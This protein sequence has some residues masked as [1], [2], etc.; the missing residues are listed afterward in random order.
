M[1]HLMEM[2]LIS[3]RSKSY[4]LSTKHKSLQVA[5]DCPRPEIFQPTL[6]KSPSR[7][8]RKAL[9][10]LDFR[11]ASI[12][13]WAG[14]ASLSSLSSLPSSHTLTPIPII[15]WSR[16]PSPFIILLLCVCVCSL[17]AVCRTVNRDREQRVTRQI[18]LTLTQRTFSVRFTLVC[19][20]RGRTDNDRHWTW[21]ACSRWTAS[22]HICT[23]SHTVWTRYIITGAIA[24]RMWTVDLVWMCPITSHRDYDYNRVKIVAGAGKMCS[25][26]DCEHAAKHLMT[27]PNIR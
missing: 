11:F 26:C 25:T 27:K 13:K 1:G 24:F 8:W 16:V 21:T 5:L 10:K 20:V 15:H 22:K 18:T 7:V 6:R 23:L 12:V 3:T 9:D 17:C 14:A 2:V 4:T 19:P